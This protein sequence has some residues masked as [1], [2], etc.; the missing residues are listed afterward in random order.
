VNVED[1]NRFE[2]GA[3][4]DAQALLDAGLLKKSLDGVKILGDGKLTK[5]LTVNVKAYS[6]SARQKI[7][8]AGGKAEVI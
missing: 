4:V 1:L 5:K 8:E 6:E 3:V 7:V 2:D